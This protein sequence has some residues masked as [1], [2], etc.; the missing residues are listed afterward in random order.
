MAYQSERAIVE[1]SAQTNAMGCDIKG[2]Q[3][4][5]QHVEDVDNVAVSGGLIHT[6][7]RVTPARARSDSDKADLVVFRTWI[8]E[9]AGRAGEQGRQWARIDFTGQWVVDADTLGSLHDG[10]AGQSSTGMNRR[11]ATICRTQ[12]AARRQG[13]LALLGNTGHIRVVP[14]KQTECQGLGRCDK[15]RKATSPHMPSAILYP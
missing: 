14:P 13:T 3:W 1:S 6:E 12:M 11:L 5:N 8:I 10:K 4:Q 2:R 7:W 9:A 15:G